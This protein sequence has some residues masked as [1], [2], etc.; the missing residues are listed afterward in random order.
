MSV[1]DYRG[2]KHA[3]IAGAEFKAKFIASIDGE[4]IRLRASY[5]GTVEN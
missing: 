1:A 4:N 5:D 2:F 3:T